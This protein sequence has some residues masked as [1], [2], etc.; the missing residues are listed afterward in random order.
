MQFKLCKAIN[1][2][3]GG[4]GVY[5]LFSDPHYHQSCLVAHKDNLNNLSTV[6][7]I[8]V[9]CA[10]LKIILIIHTEGMV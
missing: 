8:L 6:Y 4:G 3:K 7:P 10:K 2:Y 5:N 9:K 1:V